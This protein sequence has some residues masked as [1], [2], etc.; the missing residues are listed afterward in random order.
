MTDPF[1]IANKETE[2]PQMEGGN[3]DEGR[4]EEEGCQ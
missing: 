2:V 1:L 4:E 3:E